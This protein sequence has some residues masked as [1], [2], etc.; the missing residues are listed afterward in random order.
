M[1]WTK[2]LMFAL[3]VVTSAALAN[4]VRKGDTANRFE[5][6]E[7]LMDRVEQLDNQTVTVAG[8]VDKLIDPQSF[9]LESGGI[10]NDEIVVVMD[11]KLMDAQKAMAT[12]DA[13]LI[14]TG[15][16]RRIPVAQLRKELGWNF[17]SKW[18]EKFGRVKSFLIASEIQRKAD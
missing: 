6:V 4:T 2:T 9:I 12:D 16:V 17:D 7:D 14:V 11:K 18:D 3:V 5:D 1:K 15:T 8:E 10:I 13:N